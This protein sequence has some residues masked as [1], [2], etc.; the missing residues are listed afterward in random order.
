MTSVYISKIN[1]VSEAEE[2]YYIL[3]KDYHIFH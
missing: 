1:I 2:S 3:M